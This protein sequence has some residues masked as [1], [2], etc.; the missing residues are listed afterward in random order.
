[1]SLYEYVHSGPIIVLDPMGLQCGEL[2]QRWSFV[3]VHEHIQVASFALL[4]MYIGTEQAQRFETVLLTEF[5][6]MLPQDG[7]DLL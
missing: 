6:Q 2:Q 5:G 4:R 7:C 3:K 1:M